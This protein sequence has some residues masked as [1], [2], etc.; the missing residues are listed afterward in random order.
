[1]NELF[2]GFDYIGACIDDLLVIAKGS[3]EEHLKQ[4]NMVLEKIE[5][6]GLKMKVSKSC[7]AAHKLEYLG[8]W[9]S[10]DGIQTLVAKVEAIKKWPSLKTGVLFVVLLV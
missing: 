6:E 1:M 4:L 8:Y 10:Q 5:I 2:A 7:F 3:F 9:I